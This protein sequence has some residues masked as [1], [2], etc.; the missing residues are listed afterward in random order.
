[1][2]T[3]HQRTVN[4]PSAS[5][6]FI[7]LGQIGSN[8]ARYSAVI[9][10]NG[11]PLEP[12]SDGGLM[13]PRPLICGQVSASLS[14]EPEKAFSAQLAA[15]MSACM[16][17]P[18][19]SRPHSVEGGWWVQSCFCFAFPAPLW[20]KA[21]TVRRPKR[22]IY[23]LSNILLFQF[24]CLRSDWYMSDR[25]RAAKCDQWLFCL[26][27]ISVY[28]RLNIPNAIMCAP[29]CICSSCLPVHACGTR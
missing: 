3:Y 16:V 27:G 15:T 23:P 9:G 4:M 20:R 18:R 11:K 13:F 6:G 24:S 10:A 2:C 26:K 17:E 22:A 21:L 5:F 12:L 28:W 29:L 19:P 7:S 14:L 1:M 25:L 8:I